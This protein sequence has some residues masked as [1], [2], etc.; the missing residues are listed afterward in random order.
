MFRIS[1]LTFGLALCLPGLAVG[2]EIT[3]EQPAPGVTENRRVSQ[4]LG[5][6]VQLNDGSGYGKVEDIVLGPENQVDY[7]VVSHGNQYAMLPWTAGQFYPGRRVITYAVAPQ[8]IQPMLFAPNAWPNTLDPAFARRV[9]TAFPQARVG[10]TIRRDALRPAPAGAP[11]ATPRVE[12]PPVQRKA[13]RPGV[14]NPPARTVPAEPARAVTPKPAPPP[15]G[16]PPAEKAEPKRKAGG[17][18]KD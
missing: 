6:T 18:P 4:I 13:E 16:A 17:Q 10:Q 15:A 8:A 7:L 1:R 2:Q 9:Q 12:R 3:A 5:S 14:A 11:R